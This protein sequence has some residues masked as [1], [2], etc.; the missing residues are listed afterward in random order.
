MVVLVAKNEKWQLEDL[1]EA[2][3]GYLPEDFF[4]W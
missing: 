2:A 3:F 1:P 4:C